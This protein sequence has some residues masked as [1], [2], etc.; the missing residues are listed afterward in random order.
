MKKI[1]LIAAVLLLSSCCFCGDE[2]NEELTEFVNSYTDS[3]P[4]WWEDGGKE[5]QK[6]FAEK[7]TSDIAFAKI[8]SQN[9]HKT[10][11]TDG[12]PLFFLRHRRVIN[13]YGNINHN[14]ELVEYGERVAF[15][16]VSAVKV[17]NPLPDGSNYVYLGYTIISD[18]PSTI[19]G[20]KRDRP[21]LDLADTCAEHNEENLKS[22]KRP[23][24]NGPDFN[25]HTVYFMGTYH[26]S[27]I[28]VS[29]KCHRNAVCSDTT[30]TKA[31]TIPTKADTVPTKPN[32]TKRVIDTK[33][34]SE[35]KSKGVVIVEHNGKFDTI[36]F[37]NNKK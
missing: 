18:I 4:T 13:V 10:V 36:D 23:D 29:Y 20:D 14:N 27:Y 34:I 11:M 25:G 26:L 16:L 31:D 30:S 12:R 19:K 2:G 37:K 21:Y 15:D 1:L 7:M 28:G 17:K 32:D 8:I 33:D 24:F 22:I 6:V 5:F 9:V 3:N 35:S